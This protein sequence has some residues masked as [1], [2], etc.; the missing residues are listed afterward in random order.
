VEKGASVV[1]TTG[2]AGC[3]STL[4]ET[5]TGPLAALGLDFGVV[6]DFGVGGFV[7]AVVPPVPPPVPESLSPEP[8]LAEA[9]VFAI[10]PVLA[11]VPDVAVPFA[12]HA[13][14]VRAS[15]PAAAISAARIPGWFL[16]STTVGIYE[17]GRIT[18]SCRSAV[19]YSTSTRTG[20]WVPAGREPA[21]RAPPGREPAG[22][23]PA[24]RQAV[25]IKVST[26]AVPPIRL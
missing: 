15:V 2:H 17:R 1:P 16:M 9:V 22:L 18:V 14:A 6:L 7:V 8:A 12:P 20:R 21:G 11:S 26:R 13:A 10:G 25:A 19:G 24:N 23:V 4:K 3:C 5:M